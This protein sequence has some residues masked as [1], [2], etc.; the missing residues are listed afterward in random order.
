MEKYFEVSSDLFDKYNRIYLY[1]AGYICK[2]FIG[3]FELNY[4]KKYI[5]AILVTDLKE[6]PKEIFGIPVIKYSD[7]IITSEDALI[8]TIEYFEELETQLKK[9]LMCDI[10][11]FNQIVPYGIGIDSLSIVKWNIEINDYYKKQKENDLLFKY[12]EIETINRCN[13]ECSFC[14]VNVNEPQRK[15]KKMSIDLFKKIINELADIRYDGLLALFSNNEPFLDDRIYEVAEYARE[16]LPDAYIYLYTN[17]TML[18]ENKIKKIINSLDFIQI[19]NYYPNEEKRLNIKK[20]EEYLKLSGNIKKYNYFEVDKDAIRLSRGGNSPNSGVKYTLNAACC[21]PLVQLVI[22]P[23][24]KVSLCCND[25]L[26][27]HTM[28]DISNNTILDVWFS[29]KYKSYRDAIMKSRKNIENCKYC[30][31]ID[32]RDVWGKGKMG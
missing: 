10:F 8:I 20:I 26:G 2:W 3:N 14:P 1:G 17:G 29:S 32:R 21:L 4:I 13:G 28:G 12:V 11:S 7:T 23:D 30:N 19:D 18:D 24:G 25:A 6:N 22:R 27:E 15:Y 16:K 31:Y 9:E 5:T